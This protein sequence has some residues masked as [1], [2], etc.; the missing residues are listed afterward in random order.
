MSWSV[1]WPLALVGFIFGEY[2]F[3]G[4]CVLVHDDIL[5]SEDWASHLELEFVSRVT[6]N[7]ACLFIDEILYG[8]PKDA[9]TRRIG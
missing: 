5:L 2:I 7:A 3:G 1:L 9:L 6:S 8:G 4:G